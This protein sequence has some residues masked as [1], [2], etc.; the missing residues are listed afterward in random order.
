MA[1]LNIGKV[2]SIIGQVIAYIV[3][4]ILIIQILRVIFGGSWEIEDIILALVIFNLTIN[5]SIGG[6]IINLNNKI[7]SVNT[8]IEGHFEWHKG[9]DNHLKN[10]SKK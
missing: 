4:A 8:K 3:G 1:N 10:K 5:F 7:S 2:I 6:Y 9:K